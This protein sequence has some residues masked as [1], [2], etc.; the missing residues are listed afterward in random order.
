MDKNVEWDARRGR[1]RIQEDGV[2]GIGVQKAGEAIIQYMKMRTTG[3]LGEVPEAMKK[4][5]NRE[6]IIRP[7]SW[8]M[9]QELNKLFVSI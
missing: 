9:I 6:S 4:R 2:S 1:R 8:T 3:I 5:V 7:V